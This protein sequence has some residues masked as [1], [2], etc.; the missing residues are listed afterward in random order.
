MSNYMALATV[1]ATL[2][3]LVQEAINSQTLMLPTVTHMRPD[4]TGLPSPG[5]NI[6]LYQVTPNAAWRNVDLPARNSDGQ[7]ITRPRVALD[8]HYL[9]TFYGDDTA[10]E[11]QRL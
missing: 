2:S 1:T 3:Q 11:P 10:L 8:L 9:L 7:L 5:V 6:F 4:G